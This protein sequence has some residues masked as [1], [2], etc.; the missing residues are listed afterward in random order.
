MA[1][2]HATDGVHSDIQLPQY[3]ITPPRRCQVNRPGKN[4]EKF[5]EILLTNELAYANLSLLLAETNSSLKF[6][7]SISLKNMF[8]TRNAPTPAARRGS[9][10]VVYIFIQTAASLGRLLCAFAPSLPLHSLHT[11]IG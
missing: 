3:I 2:A 5:P 10:S 8:R 11:Q 7:L 9:F 4:S 1:P 6:L